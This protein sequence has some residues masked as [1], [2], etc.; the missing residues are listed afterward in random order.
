MWYVN[1]LS[2]FIYFILFFKYVAAPILLFGITI[3]ATKN[4]LLEPLG[5]L[6][7]LLVILSSKNKISI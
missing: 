7:R 6:Q 4:F 1:K 5:V 2:V 3:V